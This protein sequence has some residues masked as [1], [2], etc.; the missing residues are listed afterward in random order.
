MQT[1]R[2][3]M[4]FA[5]VCLLVAGLQVIALGQGRGGGH[6]GGGGGGRS[7]GGSP[8]GAGVDRGVGRSSDSSNGRADSGRGTG[9]SRSNGRSDDGLERARLQRDNARRADE[10]LLDHPEMAAHLHTTANALRSG[11]RV[12]LASNPNLKFGQ[13]VAANRLAA[14]LGRRHPN[15]TTSAILAGLARG[16]SIGRT[17]QDLGMGKSEAKD[18]QKQVEREIKDGRRG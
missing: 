1:L 4:R 8:S 7:M 3:F 5:F 11:Y 10:E 18:A 9:S 14:N 2:V 13:F 17:L 6:G 15:I 16:N 12:A